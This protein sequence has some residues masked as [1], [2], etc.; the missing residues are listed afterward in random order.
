MAALARA[1]GIEVVDAVA[2]SLPFDDDAFDLVLM[3]T[4]ICFLDD[5]ERAFDEAH[6]VLDAG[7]HLVVGLLDRETRLGRAYEARKAESEF[8]RHARFRSSD[9]VIAALARSGFGD[10]TTVQTIFDT[11]GESGRPPRVDT[12]HGEG[13][14]AVVRGRRPASQARAPG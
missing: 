4:T 11:P 3:V 7:G 2:E 5:M 12:G 1:R 14:F 6:R 10:L 9:E 8:Y 13:L